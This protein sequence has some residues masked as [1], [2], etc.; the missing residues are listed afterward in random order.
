MPTYKGTTYVEK[1]EWNF[2]QDLGLH[3]VVHGRGAKLDVISR[4]D[5]YRRAGFDII[6]GW[7]PSYWD[8]T[9][10]K[11]EYWDSDPFVERW[12]L[13]TEIL[14]KD[15]FAHPE[16]AGEMFNYVL[17]AAEYKKVI[18]NAVADG[19]PPSFYPGPQSV[20]LIRE[21][22]RGVQS[23]EH[24]YHTLSRT[25]TFDRTA[26]D[27]LP[28]PFNMRLILSKQILSSAQLAQQQSIPPDVLFSLPADRGSSTDDNKRIQWG[29]RVREQKAEIDTSTT[30]TFQMSW[31]YAGWS[32]FV[33]D[34]Y[35]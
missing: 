35:L 31:T 29:W 17:G 9:A 25:V 13:T 11:N 20:W 28:S 34:K 26:A 4:G 2:S 14:E 21:L 32:T 30:G 22:S 3:K 15:L 27:Y 5:S 1:T 6:Y 19:K 33:Y 8:L 10:T 7:G 24:E 12:S 23:Y 16:V 18:D